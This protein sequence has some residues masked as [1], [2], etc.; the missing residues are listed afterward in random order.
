[1]GR[2]VG[3][4]EAE[5]QGFLDDSYRSMSDTSFKALRRKMPLT[6]TKF[7]WNKLTAYSLAQELTS[8]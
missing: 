6:Q 1:M 8:K 2:Q 3:A 4:A 5:L 7:Q